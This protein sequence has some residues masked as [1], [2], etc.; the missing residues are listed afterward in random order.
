MQ[1]LAEVVR[2]LEARI[3]IPRKDMCVGDNTGP[4][5]LIACKW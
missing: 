4:W 5:F 2:E 1:K 3:Q